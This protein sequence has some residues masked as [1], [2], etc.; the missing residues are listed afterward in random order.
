MWIKRVFDFVFA[1]VGLIVMS[2][3]LIFISI[4][5]LIAMPGG[6]VVFR[7]ER[8]G[9]D[10][11]SFTMYK[12]RTM[13]PIHDGSSISVLGQT[14]I[15]PLGAIL[16]RT[17]LDELP[18]LWNVLIGNMSIV[19]P[20]PD[21]SGYADKLIGNQ[22]KILEFRPGITGPATLKYA[23]EE[24]VLSKQ[25]DPILYNDQVIFPDKIKINLDYV[26]NWSFWGDIKIIF[27]TIFLWRNKEG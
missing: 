16:R 21:V 25:E 17:K 9:K 3:I 26:N 6:N 1:L 18:E 23:N 15:T 7:Q 11:K 5:I 12:F 24:V 2:P 20:R 13:V 27:R 10:G 22:R 14:R 4:L 19:G 8:I